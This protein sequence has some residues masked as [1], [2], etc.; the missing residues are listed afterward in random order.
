M[1]IQTLTIIVTLLLLTAVTLVLAQ[2]GDQLFGQA[3]AAE[4]AGDLPGAIT[5]YERIV[6]DFPSNRPLVARALFQ[7][8]DCHEKLNQPA[9]SLEYFQRIVDQFKDQ[10]DT[11]TRAT[12]RLSALRPAR[13]SRGR[14][15]VYDRKGNLVNRLNTIVPNGVVSLSPDGTRVAVSRD[16]NIWSFDVASA[17]GTQISSAG[18]NYVPA[19]SPDG[20]RIAYVSWRQP[21]AGIYVRDSAGSGAEEF[22]YPETPPDSSLRWLQWPAEG[23]LLLFRGSTTQTNLVLPLQGERRA[24]EVPRLAGSN[25]WAFRS[26]FVTYLTD[27]DVY[28]QSYDLPGTETQARSALKQWKVSNGDGLGLGRWRA[29]GKEFYYVTSD[30][31]IMAVP[32]VTTPEF[33]LGRQTFLF[34]TPASFPI[35]GNIQTYADISADGQRFLFLLAVE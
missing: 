32:I 14:M 19:W 20:S 26:G 10:T 29:D 34:R 31:R 28:I 15:A 33:A 16:G 23:F 13:G 2:T 17:K 25:R 3:R 8:G 12:A 27:R 22:L 11:L 5:L 4:L 9:V 1:R 35:T 30:G 6:R 21:G 24:V 7:L 18:S